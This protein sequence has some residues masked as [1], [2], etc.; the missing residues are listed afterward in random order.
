MAPLVPGHSKVP[1]VSQV[2]LDLVMIIGSQVNHRPSHD[3]IYGN[4]LGHV[5]P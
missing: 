5:C 3:L 1:I 4:Q 2:S